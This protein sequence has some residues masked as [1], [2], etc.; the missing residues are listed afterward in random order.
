MVSI[1]PARLMMGRATS[2]VSV[3]QF[4]SSGQLVKGLDVCEE[5]K[6]KFWDRWVMEVVPLQLK[7]IRGERSH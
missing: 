5:M 6:E 3:T 2:G 7:D 4:K 1:C